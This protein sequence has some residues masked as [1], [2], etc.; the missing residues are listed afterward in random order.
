M[1][2]HRPAAYVTWSAER[3]V[4][5]DALDT[6]ADDYFLSYLPPGEK[7]GSADWSAREVSNFERLIEEHPEK[8]QDG[9]WGLLSMHHPGR[10]GAQCRAKYERLVATRPSSTAEGRLSRTGAAAAGAK[11]GAAKPTPVTDRISRDAAHGGEALL[12][13]ASAC[14]PAAGLID[15]GSPVPPLPPLSYSPSASA[16]AENEPHNTMSAVT[17]SPDRQTA[18]APLQATLPASAISSASS[19]K[20]KASSALDVPQPMAPPAKRPHKG[21]G[22][23]RVDSGSSVTSSH[24]S[25]GSRTADA[26]DAATSGGG[27]AKSGQHTRVSLRLGGVGTARLP[28]IKRKTSAVASAAASAAASASGPKSATL[29]RADLATR[30]GGECESDEG[31]AAPSAAQPA[32]KCGDG[33]GGKRARGGDATALATAAAPAAPLTIVEPGELVATAAL[34]S[35]FVP[36][37]GAQDAVPMVAVPEQKVDAAAALAGQKSALEALRLRREELKDGITTELARELGPNLGGAIGVTYPT[38]SSLEHLAA[39]VNAAPRLASAALSAHAA[40]SAL[41]HS[42][43]PSVLGVMPGVDSC[44]TAA[45]TGA[46]AAASAATAAGGQ[47]S[48]ETVRRVA[49]LLAIYGTLKAELRAREELQTESLRAM[50]RWEAA[51]RPVGPAGAVP[52]FARYDAGERPLPGALRGLLNHGC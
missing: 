3:R 18:R 19:E 30:P 41:P 6:R 29:P 49:G 9:K 46:A 16:P 26:A 5:W 33:S 34:P 51:G 43:M 14:A 37:E 36:C 24:T 12:G 52:V 45:A 17:S 32:S 20:R 31:G 22:I 38:F 15:G 10:T 23:E 40:A 28:G 48:E 35:P 42:A 7:P 1:L 44:A 50:R 27:Q 4:A 21:V 47:V 2:K 25:D 11:S 8:V 13:A 39:A